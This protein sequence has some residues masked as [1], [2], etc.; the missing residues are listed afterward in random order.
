VVLGIESV[1]GLLRAYAAAYGVL[2]S[3]GTIPQNLS[4]WIW[5]PSLI[6]AMLHAP[7]FVLTQMPKVTPAMWDWW[8]AWH[9]SEAQRYKLW[10][11]RA[12]ISSKWA[13]REYT[14]NVGDKTQK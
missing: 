12:H 11:P 2:T 10:H 9:G 14:K 13:D 3:F 6:G 7:L 1:T 5:I 8:F 4:T